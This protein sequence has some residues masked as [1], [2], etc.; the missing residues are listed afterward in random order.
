MRNSIVENN[1]ENK[2]KFH[3]Q[4]MYHYPNYKE[5][6]S[7][8][9]YNSSLEF[10]KKYPSPNLLERTSIFD[11]TTFLLTHSKGRKIYL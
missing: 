5:L 6:F 10:F 4:I 9:Y 1:I 2:N 3:A 11:L 8:I 7:C